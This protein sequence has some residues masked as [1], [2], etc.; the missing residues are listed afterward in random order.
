MSGS[1]LHLSP[2][3]IRVCVM[4]AGGDSLKAIGKELRIS[5]RTVKFHM[6][7]AAKRLRGH[8]PSLLGSDRRVILAYYRE[9]AGVT[10][11]QRRRGETDQRSAA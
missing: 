4:L 2:Q 8:M 10:A 5:P 9:F 1:G 3:Q 6:E 7:G 11:F